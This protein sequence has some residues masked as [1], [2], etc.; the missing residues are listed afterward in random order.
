MRL[1]EASYAIIPN[2]IYDEQCVAND[3]V[4]SEFSV[5]AI[6]IYIY[7][8]FSFVKYPKEYR[9]VRMTILCCTI[10]FK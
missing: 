1:K 4:F 10:N 8:G 9:A 3:I 6:Y 7:I 5:S 2:N